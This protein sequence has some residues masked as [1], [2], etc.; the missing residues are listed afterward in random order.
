MAARARPLG[1]RP[2]R[3]LPRT[4]RAQNKQVKDAA[5][6]EGLNSEQRHRLG[7]IIEY[8]SRH[9]G[10]SHDYQTIRGLAKDIKEGKV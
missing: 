6:A 8:E 10:I 2:V 3:D 9:Q 7:R 5:Q 1:H 4:N